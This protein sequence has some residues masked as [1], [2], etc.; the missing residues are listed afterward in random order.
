MKK[1]G[2][3]MTMFL[4]FVSCAA[5]YAGEQS[6]LDK[7]KKAGVVNIGTGTTVPPMNYLDEK[8]RPLIK[9][10]SGRS[11]HCAEIFEK[12]CTVCSSLK[13]GLDVRVSVDWR[14]STEQEKA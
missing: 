9:E 2:I 14:T 11:G 3:V 5:V 10:Q 13:K 6:I 12:Y 1:M 7:V 4:A 8:L